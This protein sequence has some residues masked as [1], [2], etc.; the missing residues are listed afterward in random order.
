MR[1]IF[2]LP[3][4][5][6]RPQSR[7]PTD[8]F[9][10][11]GRHRRT[12]QGGLQVREFRLESQPGRPK[13]WNGT[14]RGFGSDGIGYGRRSRGPPGNRLVTGSNLR[15]FGLRRRRK[16]T[17]TNENRGSRKTASPLWNGAAALNRRTASRASACEATGQIGRPPSGGSW[18]E[19]RLLSG[20]RRPHP[21]GRASARPSGKR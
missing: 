1:R 18:L 3:R 14:R 6:L 11:V 5:G 21:D 15:A 8:R 2:A 7:E 9:R 4:P 12:P 16:A 10:P 13:G 20:S 19:L 17:P